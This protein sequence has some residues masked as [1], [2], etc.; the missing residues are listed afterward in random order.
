MGERWSVLIYLGDIPVDHCDVRAEHPRLCAL[1]QERF[2]EDEL[3]YKASRSSFCLFG[4]TLR[5]THQMRDF[6]KVVLCGCPVIL[7]EPCA[8][9]VEGLG[10]GAVVRPLNRRIQCDPFSDKDVLTASIQRAL[11]LDRASVALAGRTAFPDAPLVAL[12]A[13][14]FT[15]WDNDQDWDADCEAAIFAK[16]PVKRIADDLRTAAGYGSH[17]PVPK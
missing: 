14:W 6:Q 5:Q 8:V 12:D 9:D 3:L 7:P 2:L 10:I 15:E 17:G 16:A 13:E 11:A 4:S 1:R